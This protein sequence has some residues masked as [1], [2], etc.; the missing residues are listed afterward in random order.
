MFCFSR[1]HLVSNTADSN[2]QDIGSIPKGG[3]API[4]NASSDFQ[5]WKLRFKNFITYTN[6]EL[7]YSYVDKTFVPETIPSADCYKYKPD[8]PVQILVR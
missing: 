6:P 3:L 5:H 8:I 7:W 4:I 2:S 1:L